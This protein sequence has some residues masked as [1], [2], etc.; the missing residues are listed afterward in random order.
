MMPE[1]REERNARDL[2]LAD[3][4]EKHCGEIDQLLAEYR[5]LPAEVVPLGLAK[6]LA[7][8]ATSQADRRALAAQLRGGIMRRWEVVPDG[9]N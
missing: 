7:A 9:K 1:T 4:L 6:A 3:A 8:W 2:R 5:K